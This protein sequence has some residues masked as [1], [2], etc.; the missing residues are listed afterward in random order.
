[1]TNKWGYA[2]HIGFFAGLIWGLIGFV[3][4]YFEFTK[5][6][7][8]FW[9][10][11]IFE[12]AYIHSWSGH[13]TG[14]TIFVGFSILASLLYTLFFVQRRGPWPGLLYGLAWYVLIFYLIGPMLRMLPVF[15]HLSFETH[16]SECCRYALW[17]VFI[18]YS[19]ALEFTD[20]RDRETATG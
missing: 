12:R 5:V 14:L 18:G 16:A 7:P 10:R 1:M 4:Y 13:F 15:Y 17:G 3:M 19:I 6:V 20:E 2:L 8:A 11:P 9:V